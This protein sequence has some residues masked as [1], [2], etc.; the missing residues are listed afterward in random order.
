MSL[1]PWK[2]GHS[3]K[4]ATPRNK[5]FV[6]ENGNKMNQMKEREEIRQGVQDVESTRM[7]INSLTRS[8]SERHALIRTVTR[9]DGYVLEREL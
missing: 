9:Q 6:T 5:H 8:D 7:A 3:V 1:G 2:K 4:I